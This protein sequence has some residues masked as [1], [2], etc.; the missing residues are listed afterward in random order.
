MTPT[1]W[2]S[3]IHQ[4]LLTG[5]EHISWTVS[6]EW[7]LDKCDALKDIADHFWYEF[8][9]GQPYFCVALFKSG[10]NSHLMF[11]VTDNEI[12]LVQTDISADDISR[13][14]DAGEKSS[15]VLRPYQKSAL[16][17][18]HLQFRKISPISAH[19]R[20]EMLQRYQ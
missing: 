11:Y 9:C 4:F 15:P 1:T 7:L 14:L 13:S 2:P 20:A 18:A 6:S 16:M 10:Q 12:I 8:D 19:K 5:K 3:L 17:Q